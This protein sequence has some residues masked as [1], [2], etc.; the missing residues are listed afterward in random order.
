M[1]LLVW[2]SVTYQLPF[3]VRVG[4]FCRGL[5]RIRH[6][7]RVGLLLSCRDGFLRRVR[8]VCR[9]GYRRDGVAV[10]RLRLVRWN[11]IRVGPRVDRKSVV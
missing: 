7:S 9:V 6:P 4:M 11:L 5:M 3:I 2:W 8:A 10:Q 1:G